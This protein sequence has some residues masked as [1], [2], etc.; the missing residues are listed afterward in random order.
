MKKSV[1]NFFLRGN[2]KPFMSKSFIIWDNFFVLLFPKDSAYLKS[3]DIGLWEKGAKR[4]LMFKRSEQIKSKS[5]KTCS[6]RQF[7]TNFSCDKEHIWD[8]HRQKLGIIKPIP[9]I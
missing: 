8:L 2:F 5:L 3:L 9:R 1:K 7:Y 4:R 6:P